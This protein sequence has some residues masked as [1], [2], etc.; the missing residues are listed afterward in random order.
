MA[1][2]RVYANGNVQI[3]WVPE[4]DLTNPYAPSATEINSDGLNL[5]EAVSWDSSSF[6]TATE[7]NDI[8]DRSILDRGNA[9]SRGYSQFEASL[10]FFRPFSVTDTTSTFG[11]VFQAFKT[12]RVSGYL[13]VRILQ[14]TPHVAGNVTAGD[15]VSV[16]KFMAS[17]FIDDTEG[18][19]SIKYTVDFLPQG[20]LAVNTQVAGSNPVVVSVVNTTPEPG[21]ITVARATLNGHR[22]TQAVRW[23]SSN[24][25]VA[26]VSQNG[27]ITA[28]T[29]GTADISASHPAESAP[30]S[31]VTVTV[32]ID[33]GG[34]G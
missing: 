15:I 27:V 25:A 20:V 29:E 16:F 12:T 33:G 26:T 34:G 2:E 3:W 4:I 11:K 9:T 21:D 14:G 31:P 6:P 22:F 28:L 1:D 17:T 5:T 18:E 8:D 10:A 32:A 23:E 7:S 19:D 24:P 30:M 13:V